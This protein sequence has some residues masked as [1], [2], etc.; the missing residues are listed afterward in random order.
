MVDTEMIYK[1]KIQIDTNINISFSPT[2][3][4]T[5]SRGARAD[6][7]DE[8]MLLAVFIMENHLI[9]RNVGMDLSG[10]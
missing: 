6:D 5:D 8:A 10:I 2:L 3:E 7:C 9:V 1:V 4:N